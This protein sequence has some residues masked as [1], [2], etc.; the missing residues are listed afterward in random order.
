MNAVKPVPLQSAGTDRFNRPVITFLLG[1]RFRLA[2]FVLSLIAAATFSIALTVIQIMD[3]ALEDSLVK[4]GSAITQAAA[5]PAGYSLLANDRLA[6]DNLAA[7][8]KHSQDGLEYV[9]ILGLDQKILAHNQLD[10]VGHSFSFLSGAELGG[11]DEISTV[12]GFHNGQECFEVR[13]PI[14]FAEQRVGEV[15]I[16]ISSQQLLILKT[17]AHR[18]I[19][20]IAALVISL[21]LIGSLFIASVFT[22]PIERLTDGVA[23]LQMDEL[24]TD[25]P[26][27]SR[28]ELGVLTRNF[29]QMAR[30]IQQQKMG[31]GDYAKELE[32]SYNDMVR[33]LAAALDARDNYT[34][35]HSAR[36]ARFALGLAEE[37]GFEPE[38]LKEL[39]LACLL[40]DIGKIHVSD[41][42]LNKQTSLDQAEVSEMSQHPV[43]GSKILELTPSLHKYIPAVKHHHERFDG[44]GY[45]DRLCG[46]TIPLHAQ[47]LA[48]ADTYDAMTSSRPYRKGLSREDSL[49][50]IRRCS[51]SQ[52]NPD[53]ADLFVEVVLNMP[54][55]TMDDLIPAEYLCAS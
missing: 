7:Q 27:R 20:W 38:E 53:L 19:F 6:L 31:L 8:I 10:L 12:R 44:T 48:L 22:R 39:E 46:D 52:F 16:G 47:I 32:S 9:A 21:A 36:V 50:E 41:A 18:Q 49:N 25:I 37:L 55:D 5:I 1:I 51:G 33:I 30:T 40:H 26:V 3:Q 14:F 4:R 11:S 23:K 45:P 35:G 2:L 28:N 29:N 42:V 13:R 34:Y 15:V 43:L 17:S 24:T 54:F